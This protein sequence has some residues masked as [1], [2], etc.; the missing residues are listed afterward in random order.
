MTNLL[1]HSNAP[2]TLTGYGLQTALFVPRIRDLGY[3]ITLNCPMSLVG[4]PIQW[5]GMTVLG[6]SGDSLGNDS[7]P[8]RASQHDLTIT[9]CDLFG[10]FP[11]SG[12]LAG[13]KMAH[14]MPVDC[15]PMGEVDL[16]ALR[17]SGGVPVAMSRF[18]ERMMLREGFEPL[19]VPH[20]VACDVF[21]PGD[22]ME[23]RR[24][25]GISAETFVIGMVAVNKP[26]SRKG[27]DQQ[28]QAFASFRA[29]HPDSVML[30]HMPAHGGWEIQKI[31][32]DLG[33][34][35]AVQFPDQHQLASQMITWP[36][37]ASWY[38]SLDVL[39]ACSEAEGFGVPLIEAQ[40]CGTPVITTAASATAELCASGW[41]AGGQRHWVGRH[42]AWWL[43]PD[44]DE[45]DSLYEQAWDVREHETRGRSDEPAPGHDREAAREFAL[46]Y[47]VAAVTDA[48]WKPALDEIRSRLDIP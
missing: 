20:G 5:E 15:D 32:L 16:A 36:A 12:Q 43:T 39:S 37:M 34:A 45:I 2:I 29:R 3:E 35:S 48:Y 33:I 23:Y 47:D 28:L 8:F 42:E 1:W 9:L 26:D 46:G 40:A 30:L 31:A 14:W 27:I 44:V 18:G 13:K 19:Y 7:L 10:L 24:H 4:A 17:A 41:L 6:N 25:A 22:R 21:C 11:C 38:R